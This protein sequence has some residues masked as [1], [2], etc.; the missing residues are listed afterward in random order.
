MT[1][2]TMNDDRG[3]AIKRPY[4]GYLLSAKPGNAGKNCA[5]FLDFEFH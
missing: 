1:A 2:L 4:P 3:Q 5:P